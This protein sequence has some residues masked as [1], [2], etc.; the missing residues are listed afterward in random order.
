MR[1][2]YHKAV[3]IWEMMF[4]HLRLWA[5][6]DRNK[7]GFPSQRKAVAKSLAQVCASIEIYGLAYRGTLRMVSRNS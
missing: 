1:H 3:A 5:F 2:L 7:V 4:E 6:G